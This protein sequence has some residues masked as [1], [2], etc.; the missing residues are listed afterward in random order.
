MHRTAAALTLAG[1]ALLFSR[2]PEA[3]SGRWETLGYHDRQWICEE[4]RSAE[5]ERATL[6]EIGALA[7]QP[8]DNPLRQEAYRR[9]H[10]RVR[11]RYRCE[12]E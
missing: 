10:P 11:P 12:Q 8:P 4:V 3:A 1:W 5:I 9:A 7:R 2:N 6:A